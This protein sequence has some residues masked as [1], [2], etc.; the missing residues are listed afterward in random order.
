MQP[1]H[2][3]F[4]S[5]FSPV[6][7]PST[8][9]VRL[10]IVPPSHVTI[11]PLPGPQPAL[12]SLWSLG[13]HPPIRTK[14]YLRAFPVLGVTL[15]CGTVGPPA[16]HYSLYT[17]L[18]LFLI[19]SRGTTVQREED[20]ALSQTNLDSDSSPVTSKLCDHSQFI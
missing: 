7:P 18:P 4:S 5:S 3:G 9:P 19:I 15:A 20:W 17:A 6:P 16:S 13:V 11:S 8:Q 14:P 1:T 10:L 12:P 2:V